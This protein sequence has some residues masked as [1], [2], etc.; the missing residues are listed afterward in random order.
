MTD[1]KKSKKEEKERG[2]EQ[3]FVPGLDELALR[4][5]V[6]EVEEPYTGIVLFGKSGKA[7]HLVQILAHQVQFTAEAVALTINIL[8]EIRK[9]AKPSA[10]DERTGQPEKADPP[11]GDPEGH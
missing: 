1:K 11:T 6:P 4:L 10:S 5:Q 8:E 7:Y 2:F 9:E 3:E